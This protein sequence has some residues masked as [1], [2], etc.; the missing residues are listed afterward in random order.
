MTVTLCADCCEN[1]YENTDEHVQ[2][3]VDTDLQAPPLQHS[4]PIRALLFCLAILLWNAQSRQ[5]FAQQGLNSINFELQNF[6]QFAT[7]RPSPCA[8]ATQ[9]TQDLKMR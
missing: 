7:S 1:E 5:Q 6:G 3:A 2:Y 4:Q 9:N 8:L